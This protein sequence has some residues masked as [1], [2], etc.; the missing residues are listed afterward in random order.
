MKIQRLIAVAAVLVS[1]VAMGQGKDR[2]QEPG[3]AESR[4]KGEKQA[5]VKDFTHPKTEVRGVWFARNDMEDATRE[6]LAGKLEAIKK[7]NFNTVL[8]D[9]WFQGYVP[10]PGSKYVP[11]YPKFKDQPDDLIAFLVKEAHARGLRVEFWPSYGFYAYFT[12]DHTKDPSRGAVLDA[13]PEL[14][15]V[16]SDGGSVLHRSF[17]DFY[18]LCPSNPKSYGLL[19]A[20]YAEQVGKYDVDGLS[21]DRIRYPEENFCFCD[22]CKTHFKQ[23]TG[24][25]LKAFAEGSPEGA[26]FL[27]WRREQTVK[28][29]ETIR[30]AALKA[31]PGI[32]MTAYVLSPTEM[33]SKAQGWDLW[34]KHDLLDAVAV[35]MYGE[36]PRPTMTR[37]IELLGNRPEKLICALNA[38][39]GADVYTS[40][41]QV[42]RGFGTIGQFTWYLAPALKVLPEL[43]AGPYAEPAVSSLPRP[44]K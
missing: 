27:E 5:L 40:N 10:Y 32:A 17:G 22:Y 16:D 34:M 2:S 13:H 9:T 37:A 33:N 35:S 24:M 18:S 19:A 26:K 36:D 41:I 30:E 8:I 28:A 11:L 4:V 25:E 44:E 21:L 39:L 7:A 6:Q 38:E 31:R 12:P 29:V 3:Y 15:A 43:K 20:L 14:V 23:D 1:S 42:G